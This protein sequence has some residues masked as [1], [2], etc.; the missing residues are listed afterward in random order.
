MPKK[1]DDIRAR[2]YRQV[3]AHVG[4]RIR[5]ARNLKGLTGPDLCQMMGRSTSWLSFVEKGQNAVN[6]MDLLTL[7]EILEQPFDFFLSDTEHVSS[8]RAP[9]N[10]A[11]WRMMFPG[12]PDRAAA[13]EAI[14]GVYRNAQRVFRA[15]IKA[16]IGA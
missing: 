3:A 12:E 15:Q 4:I 11:D 13:H 9:A 2:K 5:E 16:G 14:D 1:Y 7:S 8:F 6:V 10:T